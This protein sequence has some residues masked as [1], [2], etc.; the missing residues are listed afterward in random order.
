V[1]IFFDVDYTLIT[2]DVKLRPGVREVFER[3]RADGHIIYLWSGVGPR[4]EIVRR[5]DLQEL[6]ADCYWKPLYNHHARM[7]EL[8]IAVRPDFVIDDHQEIIDVF[9]GTLIAEPRIPLDSDKEMWRVYDEIAA[10]VANGA[11][12]PTTLADG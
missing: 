10:F 1:N 5:F 6:V 12:S 2:W 4:W 11:S 7:P 3:L 8:G 9:T